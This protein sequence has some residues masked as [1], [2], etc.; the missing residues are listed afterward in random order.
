MPTYPFAERTRFSYRQDP[1]AFRSP[2][3]SEPG[4]LH[5]AIDLYAADLTM[6]YACEAG[7]I[8]RDPYP[9][10]RYSLTAPYVDAIEIETADGRIMR[11]CEMKFR[12]ALKAG[13]QVSEGELLGNL[14]AMPGLRPPGDCMLHFELYAGTAKGPLT[15]GSLPFR[16]RADLVDPTGYMD[17]CVLR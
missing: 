6:V 2:R 9:F 17:S 10:V 5:G 14:R 15:G 16:R 11:Y 8:V 7:R 12:A 3:N 13:V 4:R 1:R